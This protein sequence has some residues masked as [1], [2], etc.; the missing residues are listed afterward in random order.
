MEPSGTIQGLLEHSKN[1][2]EFIAGAKKVWSKYRS[3][4]RKVIRGRPSVWKP[5][6]SAVNAWYRDNKKDQRF[7]KPTDYQLIQHVLSQHPGLREDAVRKYVKLDRLSRKPPQDRS[8]NEW[9]YLNKRASF[10]LEEEFITMQV[11]LSSKDSDK[12]VSEIVEMIKERISSALQ[13]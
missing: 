2:K 6:I 3:P 8:L 12:S 5:I 1:Q 11:E 13:K 7:Q 4:K 10:F 9:Q